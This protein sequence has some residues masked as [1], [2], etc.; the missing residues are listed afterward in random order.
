[1]ALTFVNCQNLW[2]GYFAVLSGQA[3]F[4]CMKACVH[5][6]EFAPVILF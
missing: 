6:L 2:A 3:S 1:M 4:L 5:I